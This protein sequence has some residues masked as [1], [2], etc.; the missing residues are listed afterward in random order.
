VAEVEIFSACFVL[1]A[2]PLCLALGVVSGINDNRASTIWSYDSRERI[3]LV[4]GVLFLAYAFG[5]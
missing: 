4:E 2:S 1:S 3:T 5:R